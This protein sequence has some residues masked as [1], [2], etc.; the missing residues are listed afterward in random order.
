MSALGIAAV[1]LAA[2]GLLAT[3]VVMLLVHL[4][5]EPL[6]SRD[7]ALR[8]AAGHAPR[9]PWIQIRFR[10]GW[11]MRPYWRGVR[12]THEPWPYDTRRIEHVYEVCL[13]NGHVFGVAVLGRTSPNAREGEDRG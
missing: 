9:E 10:H 11:V 1:I 8:V 12:A 6:H 3:V 4:G 7:N 5:V 2:G 13:P